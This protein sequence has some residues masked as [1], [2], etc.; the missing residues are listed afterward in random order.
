MLVELACASSGS[1]CAGKV[2]LR[3]KGTVVKH[4]KK[5]KITLVL[6][7]KNYA[8]GSGHTATTTGPLR[9]GGKRLLKVRGKLA[10]KGTVTVTQANGHTTTGATFKLTLKKL[11]KKRK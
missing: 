6:A 5:H 3:Y 9:A 11:A 8:I 7:G 4:H 2:T 1:N 10:T